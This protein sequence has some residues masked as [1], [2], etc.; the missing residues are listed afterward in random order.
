MSQCY[1]KSAPNPPLPQSG[2]LNDFEASLIVEL[3]TR[4]VLERIHGLSK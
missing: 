4:P 2:T 1:R 3:G